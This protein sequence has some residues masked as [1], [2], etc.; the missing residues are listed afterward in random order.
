VVDIIFGTTSLTVRRCSDIP[1]F[2]SLVV[3]L[4]FAGSFLRCLRAE[5]LL[6][7]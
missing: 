3:L 1:P 2:R 6:T 5:I 7:I 4:V